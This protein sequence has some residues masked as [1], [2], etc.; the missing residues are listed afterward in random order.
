MYAPAEFQLAKSALRVFLRGDPLLHARA[1]QARIA[2]ASRWVEAQEP[3][4]VVAQ[5]LRN[6]P[7]SDQL[8]QLLNSPVGQLALQA[9]AFEFPGWKLVFDLLPA[10]AE[11]VCAER[12]QGRQQ[13]T[14]GAALMVAG[15][16][17]IALALF[18]KKS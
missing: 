11:A 3:Q 12:R 9:L 4:A 10:A 14:A 17:L 6:Q 7:N 15:V 16:G 1:Q 13:T 8:C 2:S 5:A 18:G